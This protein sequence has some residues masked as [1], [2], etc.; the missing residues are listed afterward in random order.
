MNS[1]TSLRVKVTTISALIK[2]KAVILVLATTTSKSTYERILKKKILL[3]GLKRRVLERSRS[4]FLNIKD[5]HGQKAKLLADQP[6]LPKIHR[7]VL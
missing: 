5:R 3:L 7:E 2:L 6:V 1:L 4:R